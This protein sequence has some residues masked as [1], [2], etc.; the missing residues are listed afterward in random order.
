[1]YTQRL[2]L[3]N[4]YKRLGWFLL[5]PGV[6]LGII[7][8]AQDSADPWLAVMVHLPRFFIGGD[9]FSLSVNILPTLAGIL[10]I[11]G[12]LFVG[13][14]KEKNEDEFI[15]KLRLNALLWA[16]LINY[17]LLAIAFI[18]IYGLSF[19]N[20][21]LYNMFTVLFIFIIRFN[22]MLYIHFKTSSDEK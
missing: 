9:L 21:M 15:E 4:R 16:V 20:V 1:M 13:F 10:I 12:A 5:L 6:I 17:L 18:F 8:L 11:I 19:L 22:Y 7:E 14:S 2:L 3:P